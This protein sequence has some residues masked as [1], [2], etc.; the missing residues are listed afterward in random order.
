MTITAESYATVAGQVRSATEKSAEVFKQGVKAVSDRAAAVA[1]IPAIDLVQPVERYFDYVQQT[2]DLSRDLATRWAELVTSLT[3]TV[4]E[5]TE[6]VGNLVAE[7]TDTVAEL[8]V[9]QAKKAEQIAKE[10]AEKAEH[11]AK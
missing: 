1:H 2:V 9:K 7:Q 8:A 5:Q 6:K 3:G 11:D 4:R 10:Q